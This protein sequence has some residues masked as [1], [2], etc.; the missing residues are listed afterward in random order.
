M[1]NLAVIA[2]ALL[3]VCIFPSSIYA[4]QNNWIKT[5][6]T[7]KAPEDG[8]P[9]YIALAFL[10]SSPTFKFDGVESSIEI[11]SSRSLEKYPVLHVIEI[12]FTSSS[13]GYGDRS[14]VM[15]AQVLTDHTMVI[16]IEGGEVVSAVIDDVWD[17][18]K[19]T[20]MGSTDSSAGFLTPED[21]RD[22]V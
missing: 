3:V 19:Q 2:A 6:P 14:D 5:S 12:G 18:V 9:D 16:K 4:M 13:T 15:A 21:A 7:V 17:E 10:K 20:N 11:L 1:K 22:S 8:T